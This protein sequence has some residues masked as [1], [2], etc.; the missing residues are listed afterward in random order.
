MIHNGDDLVIILALC[1]S[2]EIFQIHLPRIVQTRGGVARGHGV[3]IIFTGVH[4]WGNG[5]GGGSQTTEN[6]YLQ[7]S[8]SSKIN[9]RKFGF[10]GDQKHFS[11]ES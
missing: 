11:F 5:Q 7:R 1:H 8:P 4:S 10:V 3:V 6:M 9:Y 2:V